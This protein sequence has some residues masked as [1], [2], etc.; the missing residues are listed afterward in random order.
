MTELIHLSIWLLACA[1]AWQ[2][3]NYLIEKIV[4]GQKKRHQASIGE[5][6]SAA[7]DIDVNQ[8]GHIDQADRQIIRNGYIIGKCENLII[9][10]LVLNDAFTGLALIFAAKNLVRQE[11]IKRNP[12][13]FLVGTMVNFTASLMIAF[14]AKYSLLLIG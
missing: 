7:M 6:K 10:T 9:V 5:D 13:F 4:G 12:S 1:V 2:V 14:I 8:D 11:E 3:S